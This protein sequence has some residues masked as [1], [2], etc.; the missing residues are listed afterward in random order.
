MQVS[1]VIITY[2]EEKNIRRC[3]QSISLITD[4]IV[5]VDSFSTDKTEE[6][7][8]EFNVHFIKREFKGYSEQKNFAN[9]QAK[10]DFIFSIDADEAISDELAKNIQ[11]I[12]DNLA[13]DVFWI[14]RKTNYCGKWIRHCG[15]YPDRKERL[16]NRHLG[17][18]QGQIHE[19]P[20]FPETVR[21]R[22]LNGDLLHY[23][24]YNID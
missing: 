24:Y 7:C 14:N 20:Q 16:W 18:W 1:V 5:V 23:S 2:N 15:W 8:K 22:W 19:K 9:K 17:Q 3:L 21:H 10:N 6:I 4:D 12:T 13:G 11:A